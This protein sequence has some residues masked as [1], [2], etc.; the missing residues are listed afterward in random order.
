MNDFKPVVA[1]NTHTITENNFPLVKHF[2]LKLQKSEFLDKD[3]DE[4]LSFDEVTMFRDCFGA[5]S[6]GLDYEGDIVYYNS[7][8]GS[9]YL[10]S[11]YVNAHPE[12]IITADDF[13]TQYSQLSS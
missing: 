5:S 12:I 10:S 2:L 4:I 13:L 1:I 7:K 9:L 3:Y 11:S 6:L 8:S